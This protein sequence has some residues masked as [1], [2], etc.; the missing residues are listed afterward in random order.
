MNSP[1]LLVLG[2]LLAGALGGFLGIGGGIVLM[3]LLRFLL[4]LQPADAAGTCIVAVFCTALG[5]S[6]RHLRQ[7]QLRL[8][9]LAALIVSGAAASSLCS[10]AFGHFAQRGRWL[11]LGI[12]LVFCLV[13]AR[14]IATGWPGA[15]R[16]TTVA[17]PQ[18]VDNEVRGPLALKLVIGVAA[19][20]LPGLLGIGTGGILV[21]AFTFLLRTPVKTAMAASLTCYVFTAAISSAFKLAQGHVVLAAALPLC[22]GTL[23]GSN[24][25]ALLNRRARA[26]VVQIAFG[27]VFVFVALRFIAS[28]LGV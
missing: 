17:A 4:E 24:L 8:G 3:P 7:G 14:M 11:D 19:G 21:P 27:L 13:A 28:F 10:L 12:G 22:L 25:G 20:G 6:Y 2:G 18:A 23:V 16:S 26:G 5:G 1:P 15:A 9:S